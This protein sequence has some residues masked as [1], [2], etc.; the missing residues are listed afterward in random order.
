MQDV[1]A[2]R[3]NKHRSL[4]LVALRYHI[5][6]DNFSSKEAAVKKKPRL[7]SGNKLGAR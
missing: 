6:L 5:F 1:R 7:L 4:Y 2:W 3:L